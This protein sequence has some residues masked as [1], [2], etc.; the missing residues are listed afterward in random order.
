MSCCSGD[1]QVDHSDGGR[2]IGIRSWIADIA[3]F[4]APVMIVADRTVD[5]HIKKIRK[6]IA[7]VAPGRELIRSVYGL[8]YKYSPESPDVVSSGD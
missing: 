5:S 1:S 8:G 2:M 3:S 7:E 4:A 6:K